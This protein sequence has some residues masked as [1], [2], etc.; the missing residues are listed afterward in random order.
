MKR[1]IPTVTVLVL[2]TL[3]VAS[4]AKTPRT[5]AAPLPN[6]DRNGDGGVC[7]DE[8]AASVGPDSFAHFDTDK[9]GTISW[10]E[11]A[12]FNTT[13]SSR[14]DFDALDTNHD[15]QITPDEWQH[16][17]GGSHAVLHL[18]EHLDKNRDDSLSRD[19]WQ[20]SS[21]RVAAKAR[22]PILAT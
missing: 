7:Y 21:L 13:S 5:V 2:T 3:I 18:F 17:L 19:E 16:N 20:Q 22:Q 6:L 8:F 12:Q 1:Q 14:Q 4:L 11:W 10:D 9:D 15:Q